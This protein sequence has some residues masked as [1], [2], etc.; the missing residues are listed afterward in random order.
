MVV[1]QDKKVLTVFIVPSL[2]KF[3]QYGNTHELLASNPNVQKQIREEIK[4]LISTENG[5][6]SFEKIQDFRLLPKPFE[7]GDELTAKLSVKRHVVNDK[8]KKLYESMYE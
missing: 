8:Y 7:L 4:N 2:S 3:T 5:F 1:G 6:K